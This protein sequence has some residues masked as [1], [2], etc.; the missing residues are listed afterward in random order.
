MTG[1]CLAVTRTA[2][3]ILAEAWENYLGWDVYGPRRLKR[4]GT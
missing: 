2:T 3:I 1:R 4:T